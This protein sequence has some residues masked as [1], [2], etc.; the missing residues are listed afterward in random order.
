MS[1]KRLENGPAAG[2]SQAGPTR[3]DGSSNGRRPTMPGLKALEPRIG[4][5]ESARPLAGQES[6]YVMAGKLQGP[7]SGMAL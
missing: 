1:I 7:S 3:Q 6:S 5:T 4:G 2:A